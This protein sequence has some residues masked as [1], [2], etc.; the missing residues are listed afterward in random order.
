MNFF[1]KYAL[2]L[3]E[4]SLIFIWIVQATGLVAAQNREMSIAPPIIADYWIG[5]GRPPKIPVDNFLMFVYINQADSVLD[6]NNF[7]QK[8]KSHNNLTLIGMISQLWQRELAGYHFSHLA[9]DYD[10]LTRK[11]F[12]IQSQAIHCFLIA[13]DGNILLQGRP[14]D[15]VK[16]NIE[17]LIT[18]YH[19][20]YILPD[21]VVSMNRR[22]KSPHRKDKAIRLFSIKEVDAKDSVA[23]VSFSNGFGF[24]VMRDTL[25]TIIATLLDI[26]YSNV[27]TDSLIY[28][29][30]LEI[31]SSGLGL[32]ETNLIDLLSQLYL[33]EIRRV[34]DNRQYW[35]L[36]VADSELL[37]L[38]KNQSG[39]DAFQQRADYWLG[40]GISVNE[41]VRFLEVEFGDN[42][43]F[44][45]PAFDDRLFVGLKKGQPSSYYLEI[46][47]QTYGLKMQKAFMP[48]RVVLKSLFQRP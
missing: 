6:I 27:D 10:Y 30:V 25:S 18:E 15:I 2:K 9:T 11:G 32:N 1:S 5:V 34:M 20:D 43:V 45:G 36:E 42:V 41:L 39:L 24:T 31:K 40:N 28:N 12:E 16:S 38:S 23:L 4:Y 37:N 13:P 7:Y 19:Y 33:F 14:E 8:I 48:E 29:P 35:V 22:N 44:K 47:E 21:R 3:L 26:P 46:L 17:K